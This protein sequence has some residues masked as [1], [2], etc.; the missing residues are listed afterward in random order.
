MMGDQIILEEDYD[1]NYLATEEEIIEYA[2]V[3]GI[4][5][6]N[7]REDLMWIAR[8]GISAPLPNDW[9]P[10]QD[11]AGGD[12]YYFNFTSGESTWDHP[13]DEFYRRMVNEQR[14][15]MKLSGGGGGGGGSGGG[16][17]KDGKKKKEKVEKKGKE[18]EKKELGKKL[19]GSL[20]PLKGES[21]LGSTL[22]TLGSTKGTGQLNPLGSLKGAGSTLG[23]TLG[24]SGGLGGTSDS[25][26][27]LKGSSANQKKSLGLSSLKGTREENI[28]MMPDFSDEDSGTPRLNLDLDLQDIGGLGY[29]DSDSSE[30]DI[31]G[32]EVSDSDD[33]DDLDVDFGIDANLSKRL[34]LM[35]IDSLTPAV[36]ADEPIKSRFLKSNKKDQSIKKEDAKQ[37]DEPSTATTSTVKSNPNTMKKPVMSATPT[38]EPVVKPT[39]TIITTKADEEPQIDMKALAEKRERMEQE[40]EDKMKQETEKNLAK[41]R[42]D[43]L[44]EQ[45]ELEAKLRKDHET[46]LN[47]MRKKLEKELEDAKLEM[48]EDKEDRMRKIRE[49]VE[50]D[51]EAEEEKLI[52]EKE[53]NI[54]ALRKRVKEETEDEEA[55]MMEGKADAMRKIKE[56][57]RNEQQEQEDKLRADM[58]K[59]L[60]TLRDEVKDLQENEKKKLEEEKKKM[61]ESIHEEVAKMEEK[62]RQEL[63]DKQKKALEELKQKLD[64]EEKTSLAEIQKMHDAEKEKRTKD[65]KQK[66][67]REMD[68]LKARLQ[69]AQAEEKRRDEDKMRLAREKHSVVQDMEGEM[70][71]VLNERK[72]ELKEEQ[73]KE[74]EKM[75]KEHESNMKKMKQEMEDQV[76]S[77]RSSLQSKHEAEK[78]Q[79]ARDLEQEIK[80]VRREFNDRKEDLHAAHEDQESALR[81]TSEGLEQ[82]KKE[83]EKMK[84]DLEKEEGKMMK[85]REKLE[86]EKEK[87]GREQHDMLA[88]Q[89]GMMDSDAIKRIQDERQELMESIQEERSRVKKLEKEKNDLLTTVQRLKQENKISR[90]PLRINEDED[91][92]PFLNG[93]PRDARSSKTLKDPKTP[94]AE[95]MNLDELSQPTPSPSKELRQMIHPR[96]LN[97]TPAEREDYSFDGSDDDYLAPRRRQTSDRPSRGRRESDKS[98]RPSRLGSDRDSNGLH[99]HRSRKPRRQAWHQYATDSDETDDFTEVEIRQRMHHIDMQARLFEENGAIRRASEFLHRQR[100]NLKQRQRVLNDARLEWRRDLRN[101]QMQGLSPASA[102]VLEDARLGLEREALEL[103]K[104]MVNMSTGR[105]LIREKASKMKKMETSIMDGTSASENEFPDLK[106]SA[107]TL[108]DASSSSDPSL[109]DVEES[110]STPAAALDDPATAVLA[111]LQQLLHQQQQPP[112]TSNLNLAPS[113]D[114]VL[115]SSRIPAADDT[116]M[117]SLSVINQQLSHVMGLLNRPGVP[118][119]AEGQTNNPGTATGAQTHTGTHHTTHIS[120]EYR[121]HDPNGVPSHN[122]SRSTVP[123]QPARNV[124]SLPHSD[125]WSH[126]RPSNHAFTHDSNPAPVYTSYT[127]PVRGGFDRTPSAVS[128]PPSW[129]SSGGGNRVLPNVRFDVSSLRTTAPRETAEQALER[130]WKTYFGGRGPSA[131]S[132]PHPGVPSAT[133]GKSTFGGY[134]SA[135]DQ[136]R[137][138]R[139]SSQSSPSPRHPTAPEETSFASSTESKLQQMNDWMKD[140]RREDIGN[141]PHG[142]TPLSGRSGSTASNPQSGRRAPSTRLEL[143]DDNKI[144]IREV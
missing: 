88:S 23:S 92:E 32:V 40:E 90:V 73:K 85:R 37:P 24:K 122:A 112:V 59:S 96:D 110:I 38:T 91:D 35:D 144:R 28:Q 98:S 135:R 62:E 119:S 42:E 54:N 139:Q 57:I 53:K 33:D 1:E 6:E 133:I 74:M 15:K 66:H 12:I 71:K 95:L 72:K 44:K 102:S 46:S 89:A 9:K 121:L 84:K 64:A 140:F 115:K 143:G 138:Y 131:S 27:F 101:Q 125:G 87:I 137:S 50:G 78:K 10:C 109:S 55:M 63:Q 22:G 11:R 16:G 118:T 117:S 7:E 126:P 48:L 70:E 31:K 68:D 94:S 19:G 29:D 30:V 52:K 18:K 79:L 69:D 77:E 136:L 56:T 129:Q 108:S 142:G 127:G 20:G 83:L 17:K 76:K 105:R 124:S 14:E 36:S 114:T 34:G 104:A 65:M 111:Q 120:P 80:D 2:Q 61:M 93:N 99:E 103:D 107:L 97:R 26:R 116:V 128:Y 123:A 49:E 67:D 47:H 75:K 5:V 132:A 25:S 100:H 21:T 51:E 60:K 113:T 141:L 58:D 3:I 86:A 4:D 13:C 81:E 45:E 82:R 43:H 8:E 106:M 39:P 130:K 134:V 41:K